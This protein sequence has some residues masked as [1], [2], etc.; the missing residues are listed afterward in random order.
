MI[1][2]CSNQRGSNML[3]YQEG[4]R[5]HK[6]ERETERERVEKR[7]RERESDRGREREVQNRK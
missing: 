2:K 7:K 3:E 6:R 4:M 1:A 5:I